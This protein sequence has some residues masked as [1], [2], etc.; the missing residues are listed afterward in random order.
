MSK[1][2][3][4]VDDPN[5]AAEVEALL[6]SRGLSKQPSTTVSSRPSM[7]EPINAMEDSFPFLRRVS[8]N[9]VKREVAAP[10]PFPWRDGVQREMTTSSPFPWRDGEIQPTP[11]MVRPSMDNLLHQFKRI[12]RTPSRTPYTMDCGNFTPPTPSARLFVNSGC[13]GFV[14][15]DAHDLAMGRQLYS[16]NGCGGFEPITPSYGGCGGMMTSYPGCGGRYT[17]PSY[18]GCGGSVGTTYLSGC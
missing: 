5:V 8:P 4:V 11:K 6:R 7:G 16:S 17:T 14:A 1:K 2:V 3:F 15:A 18:G 9:P 12:M 10:S 13:G